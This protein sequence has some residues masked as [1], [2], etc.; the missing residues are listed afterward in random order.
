VQSGYTICANDANLD[1]VARSSL[2][3]GITRFRRTR[4]PKEPMWMNNRCS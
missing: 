3:D 2:I 1:L 4:E